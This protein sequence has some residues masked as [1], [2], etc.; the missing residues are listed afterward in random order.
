MTG[1]PGR[2]L[3]L[4]PRHNTAGKHDATGAF[5]PEAIRFLKHWEL[6]KNSLQ[7]FNNQLPRRERRNAVAR[8]IKLAGQF[9]T[10]A[11]FC[12]GSKGGVQ[13]GY[14]VLSCKSLAS[15]L[16]AAGCHTVVLY[17]CDTARDLDP[18]RE[19]D[20][21]PGPGGDGGF[22]D[23]LRDWTARLGR[24]C[25]VFGHAVVGHT[26]K[27]PWVRVFEPGEGQGGEWLVEPRSPGWREWRRLLDQTNH[28]FVYPF[29]LKS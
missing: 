21:E 16:V 9:E 23:C 20:L 12:H 1:S 27:A 6:P 29:T 8:Q 24:P 19:D 11:L 7:T 13:L 15:L 25:R 14:D 2:T 22:A 17:C 28:R 18:D 10:L 5:Q 3:C 4:A 26:T